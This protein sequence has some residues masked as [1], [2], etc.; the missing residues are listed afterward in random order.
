MEYE[1]I[2]FGLQPLLNS[3]DLRN[4]PVQDIFLQGYLDV[5]DQLAVHLRSESNRNL[6]RETG[7]FAQLLRV[8]NSL[9]DCSF[10]DGN[11]RV[12]YLQICSELIRSISNALV[13]N[14]ANRC[15]FWGSDYTEHNQFTDY[16]AG[17]ILT[18]TNEEEYTSTLQLRTV[19]L[20]SN[21]A[22][23]NDSYYERLATRLAYPLLSLVLSL[24]HVFHDEQYNLLFGTSFDLLCTFLN[25]KQFINLIQL[26]SLSEILIQVSGSIKTIE[27]ESDS[28]TAVTNHNNNNLSNEEEEEEEDAD[29]SFLSSL[30][31]NISHCIVKSLEPEG[32]DHSDE[33]ETSKLQQN[34]LICLEK[35]GCK[36]F[37]NKLITNREILSSVGYISSNKSYS[38]VKDVEMCIELLNHRKSSYS[39]AAAT[40]I[41]SNYVTS[42]DKANEINDKL[43]FETIVDSSTTSGDP[44]QFQGF[45][46]LMRKT[47]KPDVIVFAPKDTLIKLGQ[48]IVICHDQTSYYQGL[49]PLLEKFLEK[50]LAV[51]TT[52][53]L[54]DML[55]ASPRFSTVLCDRGIIL[56]CQTIDKLAKKHDSA[57]SPMVNKLINKVINFC[58]DKSPKQLLE[59]PLATFH[60]LRSVGIYFREVSTDL[61]TETFQKYS[62]VIEM[63]L[64]TS[65]SVQHS[66]ESAS[67]AIWNNAK[68]LAGMIVSSD[69]SEI[70]LNI[71]EVAQQCFK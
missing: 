44:I 52:K 5:L 26:S 9:L 15:V 20:I 69:S 32:F 3:V 30:S 28:D 54:T 12:E 40:M 55:S 64:K 50:L 65:L 49:S 70:P 43:P 71:R 2:L 14:D 61:Q 31:Q 19:V 58:Q 1:Q 53:V 18:L 34:L 4:L 68:F 41:L 36:E 10:Q 37:N 6:I 8:L 38:N 11:V 59:D 25:Y 23:D 16:Y 51:S 42:A 7:L 62:E 13:D 24:K 39:T 27:L 60:I 35:L 67:Q 56:S 66:T 63:L 17:K 45:L 46:T 33:L 29:D 47:L 48:V 22:L 57:I 21:L